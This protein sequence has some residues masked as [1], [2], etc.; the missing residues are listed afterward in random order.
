M[1]VNEA[2]VAKVMAET[3][4]GEL[5]AIRHLQSRAILLRRQP[6]LNRDRRI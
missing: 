4:M 3:G 5:Q 6:R 2:E 1:Y